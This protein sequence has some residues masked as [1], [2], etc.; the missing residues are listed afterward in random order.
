MQPPLTTFL[1][2]AIAMGF[3]VAGFFFL[4]FWVQIRDFL[5]LAFSIAFWL[6]ALNQTIVTV[7]EIPR[8]ELSEVYLLRLAAFLLV[9]FAVLRKNLDRGGPS[10][11]RLR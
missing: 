6:L 8:E 11:H 2:G 10:D 4:R 1:S 9:I 3:T 5:F 7:G